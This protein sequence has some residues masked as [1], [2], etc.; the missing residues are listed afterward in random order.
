MINLKDILDPSH[1][2]MLSAVKHNG[3][4]LRY[5]SYDKQTNEICL[6]AVKQRGNEFLF[7]AVVTI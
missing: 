5:I 2:T 7:P 4:Q 6:A 3:M 1:E